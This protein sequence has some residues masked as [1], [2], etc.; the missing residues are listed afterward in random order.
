M[1]VLQT[2]Y[3]PHKPP[4][5]DQDNSPLTDLVKPPLTDPDKPPL[6]DPDKPHLTDPGKPPSTAQEKPP[7]TNTDKPLSQPK[8]SPLSLI[9]VTY[10]QSSPHSYVYHKYYVGPSPPCGP[11][12]A[13]RPP[14]APYRAWT[15]SDVCCFPLPRGQGGLGWYNTPSDQV[16]TLTNVI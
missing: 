1:F 15:A 14:Q 16:L 8:R 2:P 9:S 13:P 7:L 11:S 4:H 12:Q 3:D 5:T 10:P 6:T